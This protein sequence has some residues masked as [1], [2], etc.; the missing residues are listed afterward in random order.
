[1]ITGHWHSVALPAT[2]HQRPGIIVDVNQLK[3]AEPPITAPVT[4]GDKARAP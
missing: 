2:Q 1:M 3:P 4:L